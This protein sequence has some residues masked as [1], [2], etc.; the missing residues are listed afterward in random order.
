MNINDVFYSR[1]QSFAKVNLAMN[2]LSRLVRENMTVFNYDSRTGNVSFL[3]DNDKFVTCMIESDKGIIGIRDILI[4][5]A[6]YTFSNEKI[7]TEADSYVTKFVGGLQ[8]N[9]YP[10][11]ETNFEKL[12]NVF[13]DRNRVN[14]TRSKLEKRRERFS[15]SQDILNLPEYAKLLEIR[16][17]IVSYLAENKETLLSYE[18]VVNSLKLTNALGKAFNIPKKTWDE[19][20]SESLVP[21]PFDSKKTVFEMICSQEL[22]RTELVESK[23]NFVGTWVSNAKISKLASCIYSDED[24]I[25]AALQEAINDVPYLALSSKADIKSVLMSVYEVTDIDNISQKDIREYV[26]RIFEYKKSVKAAIIKELNGSYGINVQ[27]LKFIPTFSNLAKAQSVLFEA[28]GKLG[29][30]ESVVRDV[31]LDF[32]KVLHKKSGIQTLDVNDFISEVFVAAGINNNLEIF[33]D[34]N[35][36]TVVEKVVNK[37]EFPVAKANKFGGNKGDKSKTHPGKKDYEDDDKNGNGNGKNGNGKNGDKFGGNKGDKS[38][39]RPGDED[40]EAHKGSKSKTHKGKDFEVEP[41]EDENGKPMNGKKKKKKNG[42]ADKVADDKMQ[43]DEGVDSQDDGPGDAENGKVAG[44]SDAEMGGLMG[45][46]ETLFKEIDWDSLAEDEEEMEMGSD[47]ET[48]SG[49]D[50]SDDLTDREAPGEA[51]E[52]AESETDSPV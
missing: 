24:T 51:P 47:E 22:I 34:A 5:D 12:L 35:L 7:D 43:Y 50:Y 29:G 14:E 45:E 44:L 49:T 48:E 26:S 41:E 10:N 6:T 52:G 16:D 32:A 33:R 19:L 18:D 15:S 23:E 21:V 13:E 2:Y 11:A 42:K 40:F 1:D 9:S 36:K 27:N 46:L 28:L 31:F 8:K 20:M 30:T 38:E 37:D 39:T 25:L 4:E 17:R 3:T